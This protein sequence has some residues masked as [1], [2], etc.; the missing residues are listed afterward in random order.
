MEPGKSIE[1]ERTPTS[2]GPLSYKIDSLAGEVLAS[3]DVPSRRPP[4]TL[5]LRLRLPAGEKITVVQVDDKPV[6][7]DART[8]T[9]DLSGLRGSLTVDATVRH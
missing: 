6:P 1:V 5:R 3:I 8:G 9:I 4:R 2:F 7:F